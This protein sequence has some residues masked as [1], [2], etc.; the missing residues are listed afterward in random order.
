MNYS[1]ASVSVSASWTFLALDR[2]DPE[3]IG[4]PWLV[5]RYAGR[6]HE[7]VT[8]PGQS[9]LDDHLAGELDHRFVVG[10]ALH[11]RG[12]DSPVERQVAERFRLGGHREDRHARPVGRNGPGRESAARE[13]DDQGNVQEIG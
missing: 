2:F 4:R 5:E 7:S 3:E 6:H 13:T 11:D 12:N 10:P 8:R 1:S 9:L